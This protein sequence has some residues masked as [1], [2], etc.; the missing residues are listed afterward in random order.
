MNVV[1]ELFLVLW[2]VVALPALGEQAQSSPPGASPQRETTQDHRQHT[3]AAQ[4]VLTNEDVVG[5]L[6][7]GL[8]PEIV[9]AKIKA[10][11]SSFDTSPATLEALRNA[12]V[13]DQVIVAMVQAP[14]TTP[15]SREP[16][17]TRVYVTDSQSWSLVGWSASHGSVYTTPSGRV[18]GSWGG[19]GVTRGGARPQTAEIIKTV[20]QRCPELV[21]T[22]V[23]ANADYALLLDHEGG[24][25]WWRHKNKVAVFDKDGDSIFSNSTLSLGGAVE[26]AC[27]AI[28]KDLGAR[29]AK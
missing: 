2:S 28:R 12:G 26:G 4:K 14:P 24:K 6:K 21:V 25:H 19:F 17:R 10:S 27:Q 23:P 29:Q 5:M 13:P 15:P 3:P 9:V 7:A 20:G 11:A 8:T 16:E 22:D 18:E 1:V